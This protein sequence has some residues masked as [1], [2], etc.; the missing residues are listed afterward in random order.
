MPTLNKAARWRLTGLALAAIAFAFTAVDGVFG[1]RDL[2]HLWRGISEGRPIITSSHYAGTALLL[3]PMG[4]SFGFL[5]LLAKQ[6]T[7]EQMK[8][9]AGHRSRWGDAYLIFIAGSMLAAFG[10]PIVQYVV[11][12][13]LAT[14]RGY[15]SCPTPD[16]PRHQPDRWARPGTPCPGN[17]ADPNS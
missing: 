17:G 5:F 8:I 3:A 14:S 12:D 16:W 15:A 6:A 9:T 10:A 1:T 4:F 13:D 11:V 7:P 2:L